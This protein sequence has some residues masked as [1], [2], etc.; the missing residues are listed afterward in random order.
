MR[1]RQ[2]LRS[3]LWRIPVEQEVREELAHHV[4]LRTRELIDSGVDPETARAEALGRFGDVNRFQ[5]HLAEI[6]RRR[7]RTLAWREWL[8][9]LKQD[10]RFSLRQCRLHPGFTLAAV[11]TLSLGIGAT[12]S[13]FGVVYAVALQPFPFA[14]PDRVLYVQMSWRGQSSGASGGNYNYM[15][16]HNTSLEH[17]AAVSYSSFNLADTE[18]PERLLGMR[19]TWNYFPILGVAPLHGRTFTADEDQPGRP[20]VVVLSHRLWRRRFG[21]DPSTIGREIRLS[22]QPYQVIGVMPPKLDEVAGNEQLWVPAAFTAAR[23]AM[24]D[25][26]YLELYALRR[27][28]ATLAQV[29][30]DLSRVVDGLRR[31]H[32]E[33][34][35]ERGVDV[36]VYGEFRTESLRTRLVVLQATV[37]LVLLIACGNVANLLLAR[38][39]TRSRELAIRAAIGAG[40]GRIV[41]QVLTE[42]LVLATIGGLSGVLLAWWLLPVLIANAPNWDRLETASINGPVLA[43]ALGLVAAS[44]ILVGLLPAWQATR[45]KDLRQ[46]LGDGKGSQGGVR[47]L[48]RQTI[49]AAQA[50]LVL[51]ALSAATLLTRS[52]INLEQ[53]PLG[54]DPSGMLVAR[55]GLV[56][57]RYQSPDHIKAT[58]EQLLENLQSS[59]GVAMAALDSQPPLV[60][61]GGINGLVREGLEPRME[62][63]ILSQSHFVTPDYFRVLGI[64]LKTG[65]HFTPEDVRTA[66]LVMIINE[67]LARQAFGSENPIGKR[68][69]CCEG[70]T[71]KRSWKTVIAVATDVRSRGPGIPPRPEF[72]LPIAQLPEAAWAWVQNTLLVVVRPSTGDPTAMAPVIRDAVRKIDT[73]LPV[74]GVGTFEEG[75]RL[76][77]LQRRFNTWLM[78]LLAGAGL[79]LAALGIYSVIAWLVSQRTREIGLRMALGASMNDVVRQVTVHG[80][81]PVAVGVVLGVFGALASGELLKSQLFQVSARDPVSL[82]IVVALML[83]V[84]TLA[85]IIPAW[86]ASSIDPAR[87]LRDG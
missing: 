69:D 27:E 29:R 38:L 60:G 73:S 66:P 37:I 14:D 33:F 50:A 55:V 15:R 18:T 25:E 13:I 52:A 42:S 74:F 46:E 30:D 23:L 40:R 68:F 80:L 5:R 47:P 71:G 63:A 20:R 39:A 59:P 56:G 45:R 48:V 31:D 21:S 4:E 77:L 57:P 43:V 67:T 44:A 6:A 84:A 34:N 79:V 61:G 17:L 16:E 87:A 54:F 51:T 83:T 76:I 10:L 22:G 70:G 86:R 41:R 78:A 9:E 65:R 3:A 64:A 49:I 24:F 26:H 36:Q 82:G 7:D 11:L 75:L 19:V 62:N 85:A 58:F 28:T 8:D 81:K 32:A 1:I 2:R 53:V 12:T 72:Y 35:K